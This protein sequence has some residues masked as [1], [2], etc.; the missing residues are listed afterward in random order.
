MNAHHLRFQLSSAQHHQQ[1]QPNVEFLRLQPFQTVCQESRLN[2]NQPQ[3]HRILRTFLHRLLLH[4]MHIP[5][6]ITVH[7]SRIFHI[8]LLVNSVTCP[9]SITILLA[10]TMNI[11]SSPCC[12][13]R[14]SN[15]LFKLHCTF[16]LL[17]SSSEITRLLCTII[18][19]SGDA[20]DTLENSWT[21][22]RAV[23]LFCWQLK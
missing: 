18:T 1:H 16:S 12:R 14:R 11:M 15:E 13:S 19:V 4:H 7:S 8:V 9:L 17:E 2:R 20:F 3:D 23:E 22:H 5:I 10:N 6:L 21:F